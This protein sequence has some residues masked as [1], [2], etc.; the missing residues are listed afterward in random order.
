[1]KKKSKDIPYIPHQDIW[2]EHFPTPGKL[3]PSNFGHMFCEPNSQYN[4][5]LRT[6]NNL[7]KNKQK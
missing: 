3:R 1:M 4:Q 2:S 7:K 6:Q 5:L